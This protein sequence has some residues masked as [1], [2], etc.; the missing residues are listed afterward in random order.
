[1]YN[2]RCLVSYD[3][4]NVSGWSVAIDP[5]NCERLHAVDVFEKCKELDNVGTGFGDRLVVLC[6]ADVEAGSGVQKAA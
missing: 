3:S 5:A 1:M 6:A 2:V 4:I